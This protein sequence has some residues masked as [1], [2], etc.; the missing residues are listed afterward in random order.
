MDLYCPLGGTP[1]PLATISSCPVA[2][3]GTFE[4]LESVQAPSGASL[5]IPAVRLE[6]Q[7]RQS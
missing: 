6:R 4:R 2:V 5:D 3:S 1:A 7:Q